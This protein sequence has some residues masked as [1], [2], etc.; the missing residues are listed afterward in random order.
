[1]P[2]AALSGASAS[3]TVRR[4]ATGRLC[5]KLR[6]NC[7]SWSHPLPSSYGWG[8]VE[9]GPVGSRWEKGGS[10]VAGV[11]V[12]PWR[13]RMYGIYGVPLTINKNPRYVRINL[14]Y[15]RIRH[16]SVHMIPSPNDR[17]AR[18]KCTTWYN[19]WLNNAFW[20][21]WSPCETW[22]YCTVDGRNP[23]PVDRCFSMFIPLLKEF[24]PR[25]CRTLQPS[26]V[27]PLFENGEWLKLNL[28]ISFLGCNLH[29]IPVID[30]Y[31]SFGF[32]WKWECAVWWEYLEVQ[33]QFFGYN[34]IIC[35]CI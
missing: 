13:I 34:I 23:A 31:T 25:W 11:V 30:W 6:Y 10:L 18:E 12:V 22:M 15:L 24:Q 1:M 14:P 29:Y 16:G 8:P 4:F 3:A 28:P 35:I 32:I 20:K 27:C 2:P 5:R 33:V 19:G 9:L 26:T 17:L 21:M 7:C